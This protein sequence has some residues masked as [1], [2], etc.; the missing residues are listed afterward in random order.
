M[1]PMYLPADVKSRL[2]I[3]TQPTAN[4]QKR[5][6]GYWQKPPNFK[7]LY[8]FGCGG[9]PGGGGGQSAATGTSR[10]G[11]GAGCGAYCGSVF[12]PG[13]MCPDVLGFVVGQ[14]GA[15]GAANGGIGE[16]GYSTLIFTPFNQAAG[17]EIGGTNNGGGNFGGLGT[18]GGG[19]SAPNPQALFNLLPAVNGPT[20]FGANGGAGVAGNAGTAA[21]SL[22]GHGGGGGGGCTTLDVG[23]AGGAGG[24]GPFG[25]ASANGG[26]TSLLEGGGGLSLFRPF[27][28]ASG[29]GGGAGNGTGTGGRGGNGGI[30]CGGGGGGAGVT[31]G[32]GG[33]GGPGALLLIWW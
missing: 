12:L 11:G 31:G 6:T 25:L 28:L 17:I 7:G 3:G 26:T 9:A 22:I 19:G 29:G 8:L 27:L 4:S 10:T 1:Y 15:G 32:V 16:T 23:L 5:P 24:I 2:I 21:V 13:L 33:D 20:Q 14:G 30:G 18:S